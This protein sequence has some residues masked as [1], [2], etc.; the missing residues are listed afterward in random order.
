VA[1][2]KALPRKN[3]SDIER[4]KIERLLGEDFDTIKA[5]RAALKRESKPV[6]E[7][8]FKAA[9]A[10]AQ[11][12][13]ALAK[14]YVLPKLPNKKNYTVREL[15]GKQ[16]RSLESLITDNNAAL[17]LDSHLLKPG[18][19]WGAVIPY[20]YTGRDLEIHK[21]QARTYQLYGRLDQLFKKITRYITHGLKQKP[22][23]RN[24]DKF[25][26]DVKIVKFGKPGEDLRIA[27][28]ANREAKKV[29]VERN[30]ERRQYVSN[31]IKKAE[32]ENVKLKKQLARERAKKSN[33]K[34]G[35]K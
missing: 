23:Q 19:Q 21:G 26:S 32:R 20:D 15:N 1:K 34:K 31:R 24:I 14:P 3:P 28:Q 18:E 7:K 5:A 10:K 13:R 2:R 17:Q 12:T 27:R 30:K 16:R 11:V 33:K 35:K 22:T 8:T 25:L 29:E 9:K 4:R 6:T